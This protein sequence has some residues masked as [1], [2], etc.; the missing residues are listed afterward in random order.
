M[1]DEANVGLIDGVA[2][3]SAQDAFCSHI[4]CR[5]SRIY[6]QSPRGNDLEIGIAGSSGGGLPDV[7]VVANRSRV[8]LAGRDVYAAVFEHVRVRTRMSASVRA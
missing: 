8:A 5:I 6:D 2:D 3:I 7:G 4:G 1:R